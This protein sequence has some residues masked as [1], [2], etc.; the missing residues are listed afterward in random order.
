ML[1]PAAKSLQLAGTTAVTLTSALAQAWPGFLARF[2]HSRND[3]YVNVGFAN[4]RS[5]PK[6]RG[7][8]AFRVIKKCGKRFTNN[9]GP[10]LPSCY[11]LCSS[12]WPHLGTRFTSQL[13]RTRNGA[14]R[15]GVGLGFGWCL[16]PAGSAVVHFA[17]L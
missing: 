5:K 2:L 7:S 6:L 3:N 14:G 13:C 16:L 4:L 12:Q 11:S 17:A 10:P 8:A 15:V 9:R 1:L